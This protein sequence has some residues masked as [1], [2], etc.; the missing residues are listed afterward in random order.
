MATLRGLATR[1]MGRQKNHPSARGGSFSPPPGRAGGTLPVA[2]PGGLSARDCGGGYREGCTGHAP[3]AAW[4]PEPDSNRHAPE[5]QRGL[6]SPCLR[7]TIR[8]CRAAPRWQLTLSGGVPRSAEQW[9]DV[10]LFYRPLEGP[11]AHT[12]GLTTRPHRIPADRMPCGIDGKSPHPYGPMRQV[13]ARLRH[14][15]RHPRGPGRRRRLAF[16]LRGRLRGPENGDHPVSPGRPSD[17]AS[18]SVSYPRRT[19]P[20]L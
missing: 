14:G 17:E 2:G 18:G 3:C 11:S 13:R 9:R 6:S 16:R 1:V 4:C 19:S 8:A 5:G 15:V 7:S 20:P 10:V 12:R